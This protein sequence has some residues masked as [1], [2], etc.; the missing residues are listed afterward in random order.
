[1]RAARATLA[2][3]TTALL[4]GANPAGAEPDDVHVR[5]EGVTQT[6]FDRVVRTDG[7]DV[8]ATSD[9]QP[10]RCD[11]TNN[12]RN[13]SPGPTAT[14]ATVDALAT[15][16][17]GFDGQWFPGLDDYFIRQ[18]GPERED[19]DKLWWWGI[20]VNRAFS[21]VGGCQ[22]RMRDGDEVLWANDAFSNRPFLWLSA[23]T[24]RPTVLVG[25]P[26]TVTVGAT[27]ASTENADRAADPYLG[28]LVGA[29]TTNGQPAPAG[30]ADGGVSA[31]DGS[32]TVVF[33][34]AGWQ[35]VKA[36]GSA[37]VAGAPPAAI[38]SNSLD[39]CVEAAAGDG[40]DGAP[41]SRRPPASGGGGG[42]SAPG[43]GQGAP[44]GRGATRPAWLRRFA[45]GTL[46]DDRARGLRRSGSWRRV[47]SASAWEG[48]LS[49]GSAG[50][51]LRLRLG[52]GRPAFLLRL[53]GSSAR[54]ELHAG[55]RATAVALPAS[56]G[57]GLRIVRGPRLPRGGGVATLRVL[58][59][60]V[61]VDGAGRGA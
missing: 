32:A 34:Q 31:A 23:A 26:L 54:I 6:L 29:A 38:A 25:S 48:T 19:N 47:R 35:R 9:S 18:W 16:G 12:G 59:G 5:I 21:P 57:G 41:P 53:T 40:C 8:R 42:G 61:R 4:L 14:A 7:H 60:T 13:P 24:P 1:M 46:R 43:N 49:R 28:A 33:R 36:R 3:A 17:Q 2:V 37:G 27:N 44:G 56:S 45:A 55:G 51:E 11:G 39:V 50:A 30:V 52:G 15:L 10:R 20:L 22:V 58:G